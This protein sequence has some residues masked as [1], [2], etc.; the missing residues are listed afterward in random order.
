[1]ILQ[2][3]PTVSADALL[4]GTT[5]DSGQLVMRG[6]TLEGGRLTLYWEAINPVILDYT[7]FVN[8]QA[9]TGETVL[10]TDHAPLGSI[11]PTTLWPAGQLIRETSQLDL[12]AGQYH[13]RVGMYLLETGERLWVPSDET[14]Q[15]MV[16][17][18]EITV[19]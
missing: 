9:A 10:Q 1:M 4:N 19:P 3:E 18:G 13:L 6:Y 12:P 14:L 8:I 7:V 16:Y 11:Y 2:P 15:N 17:L 5:G